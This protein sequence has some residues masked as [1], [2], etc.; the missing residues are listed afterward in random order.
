VSLHHPPQPVARQLLQRLARPVAVAALADPVVGDDL[1]AVPGGRDR[2]RGLQAAFQRA[3]HDGVQRE[4]GQP[5]R[6]RG[7]LGAAAVVQVDAGHPAGQHVP[8]RRGEPVPHQQNRRHA[9][10]G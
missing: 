6:Q 4:R 2:R 3:G 10:R 1:L 5:G 9:F 8:G 7:R